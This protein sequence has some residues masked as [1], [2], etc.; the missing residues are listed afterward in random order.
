MSARKSGP[1]YAEGLR[2]ECTCCGNCCTG[3]EGAVWFS[4][5]EGRAMAKHLKLSYEDFL[6]RHSRVIEGHRSLNEHE[7]VHG[8]DCEFLDR[9]TEPG[10]AFCSIY[11]VRPLQCRTWPFWTEVTRSKASWDRMRKE[12]PC[13]GMGNGPLITVDEIVARIRAHREVGDT[14]W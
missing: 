8:F 5:Q 4:V 14:P 12:T 3:P 10:K 7:T 1:W 9:T 2:F 11:E 6:A 13:P